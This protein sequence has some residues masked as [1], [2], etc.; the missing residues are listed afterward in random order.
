MDA[1][2]LV[3]IILI[4]FI[5]HVVSIHTSI[6]HTSFLTNFVELLLFILHT[7]NGQSRIPLWDN[8][9]SYVLFLDFSFFSFCGILLETYALL[10]T[11]VQKSFNFVKML[12]QKLRPSSNLHL[13]A[14]NT[15][16]PL[17]MKNI[18][19]RGVLNLVATNTSTGPSQMKRIV[20]GGIH[21]DTLMT[22]TEGT[23]DI[24][25]KRTMIPH[26]TLIGQSQIQLQI[27]LP[28]D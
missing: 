20:N 24:G 10:S 17:Q 4:Q 28:L 11:F 23:G 9:I 13:V 7:S 21:L 1:F 18:L 25:L 26:Q 6:H 5:L 14:T 27:G 12:I 2:R 19:N 3:Q 8:L 15:T 16:G 22:T